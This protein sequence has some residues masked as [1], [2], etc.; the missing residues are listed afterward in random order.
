M[1]SKTKTS[2]P[3]HR[4]PE[5]KDSP[6]C[7]KMQLSKM[8][9]ETKQ[10]NRN[11]LFDKEDVLS[12]TS[13]YGCVNQIEYLGRS[14]AGASVK[15]YHVVETGDIVY[16]KSPL[17]D[18]PYGV[19]KENKG[20]P[21]IVSTLYAV[22]RTTDKACPEYLDQYF[23]G[24]YNLNSYLQP[25]VNKGAKN[26][27]KVNNS[28]VLK[29][30]IFAP[31]PD[32]QKRIADC[33]ISVDEIIFAEKKK[34]EAI[35]K[36][37]NGLVQKLFP[38]DGET[39]PELRFPEFHNAAKWDRE[40]GGQIFSQISN[41]KH[42]ADLPVLA[43]TQEHGAIPR[44]EIN[45]HVSVSEKSIENY[46][47]VEVNDF[48]ISLRSFQGGIEYSNYRGLCSP[49]YVILKNRTKIKNFYFKYLFK[50]ER[51]I[52]D[53]TKNIEGLRD[54]K[55]VSYKQFS[56]LMLPFPSL[57]EEQKKIIECLSSIDLIIANQSKKIDFLKEHKKGLMQHLFPSAEEVVE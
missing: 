51:F 50:T 43:I 12:V 23:S 20:K 27:M 36:H 16:T 37:K 21:G 8:L 30:F 24:D 18:S 29:G 4:F 44:D 28:D 45:Y 10:R 33:L 19:I 38:L 41:K 48:I 11:L 32:E 56:E 25:L 26:D 14:Y 2:N 9:T 53:M 54:G 39:T 46:K 40:P 15:D 34:L 42:N 52:R 3:K 57:E 5:F 1:S 22:Y 49:A 13:E 55:M 35:Q 47:L 6:E 17:K 31:E 7:K